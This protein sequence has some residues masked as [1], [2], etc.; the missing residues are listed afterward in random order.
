MKYTEI[1]RKWLMDGFPDLPY[2]SEEQ[3]EQG[4]L[5]LDPVTVRIRRIEQ[6]ADVWH[7]L[8]IKGRGTLQRTEVETPLDAG[9]YAALVGLLAAPPVKKLLRRYQ[10]PG[11]LELECSLVDE[12]AP[13]AFYYAEVEFDT[14]Q[15]AR[16]FV[17]PAFLG[18][19]VTN[20]PGFS[21]A[22]YYRSKLAELQNGE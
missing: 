2:T 16:A 15:D 20:E 13:S 8:T 1:E 3:M 5:S 9:Q 7:V 22:A 10:L 12:G 18:R 14:E 19:E 6:G 11:G 21:M 4:Y 17:P